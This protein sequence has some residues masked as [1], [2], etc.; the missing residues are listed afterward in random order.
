MLKAWMG[1]CSKSHKRCQDKQ[2]G[3]SPSQQVRL[4]DVNEGRL[5][6]ATLQE[7]YL[8]L[9]YVW[10]KSA[11][12]VLTASTLCRYQEEGSLNIK[13]LPRLVFDAME[14]VKVLGERY[15][16]VDTACIVQD[17]V[18]DKQRQLPIMDSIYS[19]ASIIM[20]AVV[21]SSRES[22]PRWSNGLTD[23]RKT[24]SRTRVT[25]PPTEVLDGVSYTV[26][27]PNL[28][29][30]LNASVWNSRGWTFQEG[31][32]ARRAL[33]FTEHQVYWNCVEESWCEDRYA[34][35]RNIRH[36]PTDRNSIL[37]SLYSE[38]ETSLQLEHVY[39][40]NVFCGLGTYLQ[41]VE[42]YTKR[43]FRDYADVIWAVVGILK[44][45]KDRFPRGYIWGLPYDHLDEALLWDQCCISEQK[46]AHT[47]LDEHATLCQLVVPSWTWLVKGHH[48]MYGGC[49][50]SAIV[51]C[52]TWHDP[53]KDTTEYDM[54]LR[55]NTGLKP[56]LQTSVFV[57][58]AAPRLEPGL[59]DFG[60]L[61]FT[62]QVAS[63]GL[64]RVS[65]SPDH[66]AHSNLLAQILLPSGKIAGPVLVPR[67]V[68]CSSCT[69]ND[70]RM[71]DF[72]LLSIDTGK[73]CLTLSWEGNEE[74]TPKQRQQF[75]PT[76]NLMLI[77]WRETAQG[78][79]FAV[80]LALV[81]VKLEDWD[82][83]E[84]TEQDIVL[85]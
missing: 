78:K 53:I 75:P 5:V 41:K 37:A 71:R 33:I 22:L 36:L 19:R 15:L 11:T 52:V 85:G 43:E 76:V 9:S 74:G 80:R 24:R 16:W 82:G 3:P 4:I 25:Q 67:C 59:L 26:G 77:D 21:N 7:K 64:R 42:Q 28:E 83:V 63:L 70:T 32:L 29:S 18:H 12:A 54:V 20:I 47:I 35:F 8:A 45:L 30:A 48:I 10:G 17:D 50:G 13:T 58:P 61:H 14:F 51:S 44:A 72:V 27:Q 49:P 62:A 84:M 56:A 57:G 2:L 39:G 46:V 55:D 81:R 34:E 31:L 38:A 6:N 66:K 23:Q 73:R 40:I 1:F 69:C 60:L 79:R 68:I 65:D